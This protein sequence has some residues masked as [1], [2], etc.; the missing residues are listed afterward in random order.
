MTIFDPE[1]VRKEA[2]DE[3]NAERT[4]DLK[5]KIKEKLR[6]VNKAKEVLKLLNRE[7]DDLVELGS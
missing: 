1:A 2:E 7:L 3:L 6:E 5:D 4:K